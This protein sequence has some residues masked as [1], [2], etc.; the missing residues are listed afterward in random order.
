MLNKPNIDFDREYLDL[1]RVVR[2]K[3]DTMYITLPQKF[4]KEVGIVADD[5]VYIF[6]HKLSRNG[7]VVDLY[8]LWDRKKV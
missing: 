7:K 2:C 3:N 1:R 5:E 4:V 8:T 6:V